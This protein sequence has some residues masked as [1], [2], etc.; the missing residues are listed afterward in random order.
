MSLCGHRWGDHTAGHSGNAP[1]NWQDEFSDEPIEA[2]DVKTLPNTAFVLVQG[3]RPG[4]K[5]TQIK[6]PYRDE[7]G[8]IHVG[9]LRATAV[10]IQKRL[11]E[12]IQIEVPEATKERISKARAELTQ[13]RAIT[14]TLNPTLTLTFT[15]HPHASLRPM[16]SSRPASPRRLGARGQGLSRAKRSQ[17]RP[18]HRPVRRRQRLPTTPMKR[19]PMATVPPTGMARAMARVRVPVRAAAR[20]AAAR[21][22][23]R[24]RAPVRVVRSGAECQ[25]ARRPNR[26]LRN[27]RRAR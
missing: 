22:A 15:L 20:A 27:P 8:R 14:L 7:V 24:V 26:L 4:R 13:T 9:L 1:R 11:H 25:A 17:L 12:G 18:P 23:A 6:L 3:V 19:T 21:A 5:P 16:P 2:V 10:S